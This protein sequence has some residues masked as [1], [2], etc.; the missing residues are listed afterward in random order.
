MILSRRHGFV[1]IKTIKTA[2][3]SLEI[4]LSRLAGPDDVITYLPPPD[5]A[6]RRELGASGP[7]NCMNPGWKRSLLRL[8]GRSR[9]DA[10]YFIHH[11]I[12]ATDLRARLGAE[13]GRLRRFTVV[14]DPF[15][16]AISKFFNDHRREAIPR[17]HQNRP[18]ND[19]DINAYIR[20][21]PDT[22]LT[23]WHLY[24]DG[25]HIMVTDILRYERIA[26]DLASLLRDMGIDEPVSLPRAKGAWRLDRRHYSK[27]LDPATR[28]RI[29]HVA[30]REIEAFGYHWRVPAK[31][32]GVG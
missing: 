1:F 29:E 11:N 22:D 30:A 31:A 13:W 14:R 28:A 24:A 16:R 4:F 32:E 19:A 9:H 21:M 25:D 20:A 2:S 8:A 10:T 18:H 5:E 27:I 15:D 23:N 3:T 12:S 6:L 17:L 26:D 7:Q